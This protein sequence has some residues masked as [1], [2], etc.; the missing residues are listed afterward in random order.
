MSDRLVKK[1]KRIRRIPSKHNENCGLMTS[2]QFL[3]FL[4]DIDTADWEVESICGGTEN[5][6]KTSHVTMNYIGTSGICPECRIPLSIHDRRGRIW[7]HANYG[8]AVCYIHARIPRGQC[9]RCGRIRQL[10]IPWADPNVSYTRRFMDAAVECMSQM[11]VA[12]ASRMLMASWRVLDGIVGN[13]VCRHLDSMDLSGLRRIR[14]DE[15][16]AKKNHRYITVITDADTDDI[17]FIA[18]GRRS[19]VMDEFKNWL[20]A[21]GGDPSGIELV[22]SDFGA[23]FLIGTEENLPNAEPALDPFH[24]IQMANR[25]LDRDRAAGSADNRFPG[26]IRFILLKGSESLMDG[27]RRILSEFMRINEG[28]AQSYRMKEAL[29]GA[30]KYT[31]EE[32]D[33]AHVHLAAFAKWAERKGSAGFRALGKTV[34]KYNDG[35]VRAIETGLNNGFQEG[36]NARIQL[37]KRLGRGY[38]REI[39]FA[40][41]IYFRDIFRTY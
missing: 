6:V 19:R 31:A 40:R 12:A 23:P 35:I 4:L 17:I 28:I 13:I 25:A 34:E 8:D 2:S 15:T 11:S 3:K 32:A 37:S 1:T 38:R 18:K 14:V 33:L 7:R 10:P 27:E 29:R 22:A 39:R 26:S 36:L 24:L 41:I 5:G 20:L 30:L 21:H 16:S 9:S